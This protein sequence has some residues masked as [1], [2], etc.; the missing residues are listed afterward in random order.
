MPLLAESFDF[1]HG[2][3]MKSRYSPEEVTEVPC[4]LC[5][6]EKRRRLYTELGSVGICECLSCSLIYTS[7][8][9]LEPEKVYWGDPEAIYEEARLIFE[10]RAPHHRDP[11]Y[12]H[13]MDTI[14]KFTRKKERK[15]GRKV[16]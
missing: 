8:R 12:R 6:S 3:A 14:E 10:G 7:P 13:E 16:T 11:N 4:P 1:V 15:K 9:I 2:G 5:G